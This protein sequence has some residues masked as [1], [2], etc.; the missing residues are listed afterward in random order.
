MRVLRILLNRKEVMSIVESDQVSVDREI[1]ARL[2]VGVRLLIERQSLA[3]GPY[4]SRNGF[5]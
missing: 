3:Q 5:G 1:T 2:P 4:L